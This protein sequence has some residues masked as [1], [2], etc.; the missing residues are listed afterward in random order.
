MIPLVLLG[1]AGC[2][3]RPPL[4]EALGALDLA[5]ADAAARTE[6]EHAL[7]AA[8]G[9]LGAPGAP[10][11]LRRLEASADPG[12]RS[13]ARDWLTSALAGQERWSE[14]LPRL[15]PEDAAAVGA[16]LALPS[17]GWSGDGLPVTVPLLDAAASP[18]ALV[19]V[20]FGD[21]VARLV[22]DTGAELLVLDDGL[23]ERLG[24][25]P[26]ASARVGTSTAD[27]DLP[28]VSV[29]S[30]AL[31]GLR[32]TDQPALVLDLAWLAGIG[33]PGPVDG[34]LGWSQLRQLALTLDRRG[35]RLVLEASGARVGAPVLFPADDL[36]VRASS[37][38]GVPL[39]MHLDSGA[40]ASEL[41]PASARRL[42]VPT[43]AAGQGELGGAG[44]TRTGTLRLAADFALR[45]G[46][47]EL[48]PGAWLVA[49]DREFGS[50]VRVDGV[51]GYDLLGLAP[52]CIDGPAMR[53]EL[54]AAAG[55]TCAGT[56]GP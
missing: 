8:V 6:E 30:L 38:D 54:L 41:F 17:P 48:R 20:R 22:V 35:G 31:G 53:F 36:L 24:L 33:V 56:P 40:N 15:A 14:L 44:G 46:G 51:I 18:L 3:H 37:S 28:L 23:A 50:P 45:L 12:L 4:A 2:A 34:I 10:E 13:L 43:Q 26:G 27:A 9:Q 55:A 19:E 5:A 32:W 42:G 25:R 21:E 52:V 16:V 49:E 1:T 7:V 39:V 11:Q 29:P 47:A